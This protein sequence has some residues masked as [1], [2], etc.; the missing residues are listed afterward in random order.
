MKLKK[1]LLTSIFLFICSFIS[2]NGQDNCTLACIDHL[3]TM[4]GSD[5]EVEIWA[6]DIIEE[7]NECHG[8][9]VMSIVDESGAARIENTQNWT[10]TVNDINQDFVVTV[11]DQKTG[12]SCWG[13]IRILA[14]DG[15]LEHQEFH[16]LI[17]H[18]IFGKDAECK[19]TQINFSSF[20]LNPEV[21]FNNLTFTEIHQKVYSDLFSAVEQLYI[22]NNSSLDN[23]DFPLI[24]TY[25]DLYYSNEETGQIY[26]IE[27]QYD[28]IDWCHSNDQSSEGVFTFHQKIYIN[29]IVP[30][31]SASIQYSSDSN[32]LPIHQIIVRDEVGDQF[33]PSTGSNT[34]LKQSINTAFEALQKENGTY[35]LMIEKYENC[36]EGISSLDL[37]LTI[38]HILGLQS[39]ESS[40]QI[41]AADFDENGVVNVTDLVK[42]K[43]VVLG[44]T[45][46]G[47]DS[48]WRFYREEL[49]SQENIDLENLSS[50]EPT[51]SINDTEDI[52]II[53]LKKGDVNQSSNK[54][55]E[56][57]SVEGNLYTHD[58]IVKNGSQYEIP[59]YAKQD[60]ELS[61]I[62]FKILNSKNIKLKRISSDIIKLNENDY[63]I[64]NNEMN[65]VWF[66]NEPV[67]IKEGQKLFNLSIESNKTGLLSDIPIA[68]ISQI[69]LYES[70]DI[71]DK[72]PEAISVIQSSATLATDSKMN[73][74][75]DGSTVEISSNDDQKISSIQIYDLTGK[76]LHAH[77]N[78][79]QTSHSTTIQHSGMAII[80]ILSEEGMVQT[81]KIFFQ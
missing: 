53:G 19:G 34:N 63:V 68:D 67:P 77:L 1:H 61:S 33:I 79:N 16:N 14:Y 7:I 60:Y 50:F 75:F 6:L 24:W 71:V 15:S 44:L 73:V 47:S 51:Y 41:V 4:L 35:N 58:I 21:T 46:C 23:P 55:I 52:N 81:E 62:D 31:S 20:T 43:N 2:L 49:N 39:F 59:V 27:R 36:A 12:N 25:G 26:L 11:F 72:L 37:V 5:G 65:M 57:R 32:T 17:T 42:M 8:D 13:T 45:D 76:L 38:K 29:D 54:S 10:A 64:N 56:N 66:S 18:H 3:T 40:S 69:Q 22:D 30:V 48:N 74:R 80:Q 70:S 9:I 28:F 78:I